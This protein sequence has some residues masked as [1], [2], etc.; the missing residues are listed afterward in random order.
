MFERR[1][2]RPISVGGV[3]VGGGAPVVVQAMTKTDTRDVGA[4][5]AEVRRLERAGAEIVRL[6]VPDREAARAFGAVKAVVRVPLIA[7]IHFDHRL[8]LAA[9]EAG[10][11]GLRINPGNI[12]SRER[13]AAVVRA[14]RARAVPIRIGVNSGSLE[15]GLLSKHGGVTAAAMVESALRH[16]RLLED[17]DFRLIKISLKATDIRRTLEAYRLLAAEV[18]YPFHAGITEAGRLFAGSIKSA[19]GLALLLA[20]GLA[21]TVRV[22]LTAP[23]EKEVLA[24]WEVLRGLGLR[25]RGA[26]LVS[27]PTCGRTEVDLMAVAARVERAVRGLRTPL[28]VAVMGCAVNGPGEA[29]EADIGLACG[30]GSG[31]IFKKGRPLRRVRGAGM[32]EAFIDEVK[33][34]DGEMSGRG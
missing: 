31:V 27:C 9:L 34:L 15:K 20:E 2:T 19:A 17:L 11:D 24:A 6:A 3:A 23:A 5:A 30:R 13:V 26:V 12:G 28:V 29:R 32:V 7:D 10:A 4:T 25:E 16:V 1:A 21:D 18:D 14:A 22:S 33:R 8:A